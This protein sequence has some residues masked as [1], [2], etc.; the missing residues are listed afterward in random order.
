MLAMKIQDLTTEELKNLRTEELK[1]A[2]PAG[3]PAGRA[4]RQ[5]RTW[6]IRSYVHTFF[7]FLVFLFLSLSWLWVISGQVIAEEKP[8][9]LYFINKMGLMWLQ[10]GDR[11]AMGFIWRPGIMHGRLKMGLDVNVLLSDQQIPGL[12]R[13]I[14]RYAEY[15]TEGTGFRYGEIEDVSLGYGLLMSNYS[16]NNP[17]STLISNRALGLKTYYTSDLVA[18]YSIATVGSVFGLRFTERIYPNLILGETYV[19]DSN[20]I[21]NVQ[22]GS[23]T[24][25]IPSESGGS[26]DLTIP[27]LGTRFLGGEPSFYSELAYLS[28][29]GLGLAAGVVLKYE[30]LNLGATYLRAERVMT[31]QNFVPRYFNEQ[32]EVNPLNLSSAEAYSSKEGYLFQL[33]T[34]LFNLIKLTTTY[35]DYSGSNPVLGVDLEIQPTKQGYGKLSFLQANF[36]G[37]RYIPAE[38]SGI[39]MAKFAYK[40]DE[41]TSVGVLYKQ[42]T[43]PSQYKVTHSKMFS[44]QRIF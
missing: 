19:F 21:Q 8:D 6:F 4:G 41:L 36:Q 14:L 42:A 20:G 43:D 40:L 30:L 5:E 13:A 12:D 25:N 27:I 2:V 24:V 7:G 3:P 38:S 18:A 10:E 34:I 9:E 15:D 33:K 44:I 16:T 37:I 31:H 28:G 17:G 1:N 35:E 32:Y 11:G 29:R 22:T 23:G 26:L 39:V